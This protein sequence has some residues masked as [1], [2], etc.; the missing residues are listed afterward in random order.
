MFNVVFTLQATL[1]GVGE[2]VLVGLGDKPGVGVG[3][4]VGEGDR[5][6]VFVGVGVGKGVQ[7]T[8]GLY[9]LTQ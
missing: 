7:L 6:G 4:L 5:F 9:E 8:Q 2:G 3:V 1:E